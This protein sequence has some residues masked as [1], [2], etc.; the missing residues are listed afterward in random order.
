MSRN[1]QGQSSLNSSFF[2]YVSQNII[3]MMGISAYILADTFFISRSEGADGIAALNLVLPLYSL[4]YAI[5][6]IMGVGSATRFAIGRA[7]GD[8]ETDRYFS[9]ALFFA[10]VF[11]AVFMIPG[12]FFPGRVLRLMGADEVIEAVGIPYTRIFLLFAPFFMMN[13]IFNAYVRNDGAPSLAMT[14]TFS[15]SLFNI[16]MD[17]VFM[18]PMKMGMAGAALATVFSPV[19]GIAVCSLHFFSKK[20]TV[21]FVKAVPSLKRLFHACQLG[22]AA[23][24]SEISSGVITLIFNWIILSLAGNVGVAAYGIVANVAIVATSIFNGISQGTQPLLSDVYGRGEKENV[25][26]LFTMALCSALCFGILIAVLANGIPAQLVNIFNSEQNQELADAAEL[27]V[28]I[29]FVGFVFAGLNIVGTGCLSATERA[30]W[31]F[32]ISILRGIVFISL[33]AV[34]LSKLLGMTGVWLA[35]PVAEFLSACVLFFA[36][37]KKCRTD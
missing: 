23:F 5:G 17:Y 35:F 10:M 32:A 31:S 29:Y 22:T 2:R 7:R 27:G 19:V 24:M 6:S 15:S 14:A 36:I 9:N 4:I 12:A 37:I 25:R 28:R 34:L 18:F 26:K 13:F 20:N 21:R 1:R 8:E 3:G 30:A 16:V 33:C 11:G